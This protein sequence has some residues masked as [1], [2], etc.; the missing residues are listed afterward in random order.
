M[1][2]HTVGRV[3]EREQLRAAL[4]EARTGRGQLAVI[5]G[6]PGVG[7]TTL[8]A[9]LAAMGREAGLTV[10]TGRAA[11]GG[12]SFRPLA[13]ALL[14]AVRAGLLP[15]TGE[16]RP[17]RAALGRL[18]P[19]WASSSPPETAVDPVVVLGEGLLRLFAAWDPRG[20]VLL[21]EDLHW[22]DADTLA[23]LHYL[24]SAAS[25]APLLMAATMR[26][27]P[28]S[29]A[30][31]RLLDAAGT[32]L[33]LRRF[34]PAE[35]D[36]MITLR[37]RR[38]GDADRALLRT[39]SEGLPLLV[40]ELLSAVDREDPSQQLA[41]AVPASFAALVRTR[42]D[43]LDDEGRQ[44]LSAAAALGSQPDWDL[45]PVIAGVDGAEAVSRLR[46]AVATDLLVS[47]GAALGWRHVL[48]RDA[49]WTG[50]LPP[51][52][53]TLA[54]RAAEVLLARGGP[55]YE[56]AAADLLVEAGDLDQG[57][58]VLLR[59]VDREL[60]A[61][62][63]HSAAA[64]LDRIPTTHR[65]PAASARRR[66]EL[67]R[68]TGRLDE[69]MD[70]GLPA[71]QQ[72]TGDEHAEL[73]LRLA[74]VAVLLR[75]WGDADDLVA[76]A[77]RPDDPRSLVLLADSAHGAGRIPAA[78]ELAARAVTRASTAGQLE[79]RCEALVVQARIVRLSDGERSR[80]LFREAA[81]LAGEH[82]LK[83][84]RVEA[85]LGVGTIELMYDEAST[86]L[87]EVRDLATDL[88][89]LVTA[90]GA[91]LLLADHRL[92]VEGPEP[93]AAA[94]DSL[95]ER[96][97]LLRLPGFVHAGQTLQGTALA[98]AGSRTA[99]TALLADMSAGAKLTLEFEAQVATLRAI[100]AAVEHDLV[101]AAAQLDAAVEP[102]RRHG[103]TPPLHFFGF[104]VLLRAVVGDRDEEARAWLHSSAVSM[105]RANRGALHFAEAVAAGRTG[106]R[107]RAE[108]AYG[109]GEVDLAPVPWWHR[110]LRLFT[111][112]CA[113]ADG[114]G[115]PV[116]LLRADLTAHEAAGHERLARRC[117]QLLR[118]AGAPTR[119]G[120]GNSAVP[121]ELRAAGITSREL[122]VLDL[123]S[124]GRSNA[125][126]AAALVLSI[127]TVETHV[128]N[129]LAK[130]GA[131]NR[132]ELRAWR[133]RLTP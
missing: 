116:P 70:V 17:Y 110:F 68:L 101:G 115:E 10:L 85:L 57:G 37:G 19:D 83:H 113:L 124:A 30:L 112:E 58:A 90:T 43:A 5:V 97:R 12:G 109:A 35:I 8:L 6:E 127:R 87:P 131:A 59:V 133:T 48:T 75:R 106:D 132:A 52:R 64:V 22:A 46:Q 86:V 76:R 29:P 65:A 111:L 71:L 62:A 26:R 92:V 77:R 18:I 41:A 129:L 73:C 114:W 1:P 9:E 49:I 74:R 40:D 61:A 11:E 96:G 42:L 130:T 98:V 125:E 4:A 38:L 13:A 28:S 81:E 105:R 80:S 15:D 82:G 60:A 100:C 47:D 120:R 20:C 99:L 126:T 89:L 23:L 39:R 34:G 36:A 3:A 79:V 45:V 21:V 95:V 7:K 16:L 50:L 72:A 78:A 107:E 121:P 24:A 31:D 91:E 94:A 122:D 119:R 44:V 128:A 108:Q 104:W 25:S 123:V 69:A 88:G 56:L 32:V 27:S 2:E 67:L 103:S 33:A 118:G 102:L 51:E 14:P 54:R 84:W 63:L 55:T 117:R 53:A 66:V 93:L